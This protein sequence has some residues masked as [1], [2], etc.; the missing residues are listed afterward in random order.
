MCLSMAAFAEDYTM[1]KKDGFIEEKTVSDEL[2]F[3]DMGGPSSGVPT[4]TAGYVRFVP[5]NEGDQLSIT[6]DELDLTG[7][8]KL[9]IYDGDA[10]F[11]SYYKSPKDG[12]LAELSGNVAGQTFVATSGQLS[13]LYYCKGVCSGKGWKATVTAGK[14]KDMTFVSATSIAGLASVNRGAK[15]QK[16]FG[17]SVVTDGTQNALTLNELSIDCSALANSKQVKNVRL[18]KSGVVSDDNLVATAATIGDNFTVKDVTLKNKANDFYVVA[19]ILPDA[20]GEIPSLKISSVKVAGEAR[21]PLAETGEAVTVSNV[22]LMPSEATTFT[23]SD[24]ALFYDDGGKDGKISSKFTGQVTF[25][26]AT[27]GQKVKIDFSKLAIFN[28]STTGYNDILNVYNGKEVNGDNLIATLLKETSRVVKSTADDGS[29]TVTLTSTTGVPAN[30]WEA[31]VSQFLPGDMKFKEVTASVASTDNVTA[32]DKDVQLLTVNVATDNESNAIKTTALNF[33][34]AEGVDASLINKVKVYILGETNTFATTNLFGEAAVVDGKVVVNG[35]KALVEGNNYFAV[36]ADVDDKAQNDSKV[37]LSLESVVVGGNTQTPAEE[38]SAIRTVNNICHATKGSHTHTLYGNWTFTDTKSTIYPTKY[39]YEDADYIVTFIPSETGHVAMLD[40]SKFDIEYS[41]NSWGTKAV[42]EVYSGKTTASDKLLWKLSS[43]DDAKVGPGK[44]LYSDSEDGAITI[45]FNPKTTSSYYAATGWVATVSQYKNHDMTIDSVKVTQPNIA[46]TGPNSKNELL[47]GIKI[48]TDGSLTK[49]VLKGVKLNLKGSQESLSKVAI[50]SSGNENDFAKATTEYGSLTELGDGNVTINGELTLRNEDNYMWVTFDVAADAEAGKSVDASVVSLI[51]D[52]GEVAVTD[53]DP[54]GERPIKNMLVLKKGD[55]GV[56]TVTKPILLYDDGGPDGPVTINTTSQVTFVPGIEDAVVTINTNMFSM[57]ASKMYVYSGREVNPD[58]LLGT[59]TYFFTTE[60]P[61][62]LS[63]TA[64]D[65][66]LTVKVETSGIDVDGFEVEINV[67]KRENFEVLDVKSEAAS[68]EKVL[69]GVTN[70]ELLKV[71]VSVAGDKNP[72]SVGA[73]KFTTDG[74]TS[75][76]DI[77]KASLYYTA[78][79]GNFVTENL[80]ASTTDFTNGEIVLTP[81]ET[82]KLSAVGEYYYWLAVDVKAD[83][84]DGNV[85]AAK[86]ASLNI[87]NAEVAADKITATSASRTIKKGFSG[88]HT[89]GTSANADYATFK[90]AIEALS[91]GV[92]GA[93]TFY[94][95]DGTYKEN[96]EIKNIA[97]TTAEHPIKFVSKSGNRNGVVIVGSGYTTPAYGEHKQG[98]FNVENT[99]YVTLEGMSFIPES[100]SFPYAILVYDR[101]RHFTL[102][103]CYVKGEN[104][105]SGYSG[106]N[107]LYSQVPSEE[108]RNNDYMTVEDCTFEGGYIPLYLGG[109]QTVGM[110]MERGLVVRNNNIVNPCSKGIYVSAEIDALIENNRVSTSLTERTN[111]WGMDLYRC[112]GNLIVRNNVVNNL[113]GAYSGGIYMRQCSGNDDAPAMIYNNA[114]SITKSPNSYSSGIQ[115]SVECK[116]I[117]LLYNTVSIKGG[118]YAFYISGSAKNLVLKNITVQ[119]NLLQNFVEGGS[120]LYLNDKTYLA[121]VKF[122]SNAYYYADG[123]KLVKDLANTISEYEA[124]TGD[125]TSMEEKAEFISE[126][127]LRLLSAGKLTKAMPLA[128][129]TTDITGKAR[130]TTAPTF[131]AY[132]YVVISMDAPVI[133]EGYPVAGSITKTSIDVKTKWTVGGKLYAK[134]IKSS[135]A[136]PNVADML[137]EKATDCMDGVEVTSSFTELSPN[138]PYKAYFMVESVMGVKSDIVASAEI[139]TDR[140]IAPLTLDLTSVYDAI[141]AGSSSTIEPTV[142]GGDTP[143]TY[144]WRNQMNEVVGTDAKLTVTPDHTSEYHFTVTSA[145]GQKQSAKT[146][147][148][149]TGNMIKATFDDNYLKTESYWN[150]D[151]DSGDTFYSGSFAFS[152][153]KMSEYDYWDGFAYANSKLTSFTTLSD[154]YRNIV[155]GGVD[156]SDGYAVVYSGYYSEP[157]IEVT[158][159]MDGEIVSG[160]YVTNTPYAVGSM[161]KG[162]GYTKA[163]KT[164]DYYKVIFTGHD[165]ENNTKKVEYMLADYTSAD[166]EDHYIVKDWKWVDLSALGAVSKITVT[167][168]GSQSGIPSYV[169]LDNLGASKPSGVKDVENGSV[170]IYPVPAVDVLYIDGVA[171]SSPVKVYSIGGQLVGEYQLENG[172]IDVSSLVGG[173]YIVQVTTANGVVKKQFVKM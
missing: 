5:A 104:I 172:S 39:E 59:A 82:M 136:A 23:I 157:T 105:K 126:T 114:I 146:A 19:D 132:E 68:D 33:K 98:M 90:A 128:D 17:A 122:A 69:R 106:M 149:V 127:D 65:G 64:E 102:K 169:A 91:E 141:D 101:S 156:G 83:A 133:T 61:K 10:E 72:L 31:T 164:G 25:V 11:T 15:N 155:G 12:Y 63:S 24:D 66:S 150:G 47:L 145:D 80:V 171:E 42:Y 99:S 3:Y 54:D 28:T 16:I 26:P 56:I 35:E 74:T 120:T 96:V 109:V 62:N 167:V 161:E 32:G 93:V 67:R 108:G 52:Q 51:T 107:L 97:G 130:S 76:G 34:V 138:T 173:V 119:N 6:F 115:V 81:A 111:Y 18:Y 40:F 27:E 8:A 70:A 142:E 85:I 71:K 163:F 43:A 55:N 168:M 22:I 87:A 110:A 147:V 131:G 75:V 121:D 9:Y 60:G 1:P 50:L 140:L 170:N 94:V 162:D 139:T 78:T 77:A 117:K 20:S 118:G 124:L 58:K 159:N 100:S 88:E 2:T 45:K 112:E 29:L 46:A 125:N 103:N 84:A 53:G 95:E 92:E 21:T 166:E 48:S 38:V 135:E 160:V 158:N 134:M 113:Q 89:I 143:Y 49:R 137:V 154:Q 86:L 30:G 151:K 148:Y 165:A 144:E 116:N 7:N 41:A 37:G 57:G 152:N 13:V 14:P 153:Y 73:F 36:V 79:T 129:V 123:G 4:Y 44:K